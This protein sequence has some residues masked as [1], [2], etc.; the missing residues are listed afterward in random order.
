MK[1]TSSCYCFSSVFFPTFTP[2]FHEFL[3]TNGELQDKIM[4]DKIID[5][6][7]KLEQ[8]LNQFEA[9]ISVKAPL[10]PVEVIYG[11][12]DQRPRVSRKENGVLFLY[13]GI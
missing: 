2:A 9:A 13:F 7:E 3:E 1:K 11:S 5:K 8:I 10:N 4:E 6:P 12:I